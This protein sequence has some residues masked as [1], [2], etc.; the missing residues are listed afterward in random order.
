MKDKRI[1]TPMVGGLGDILTYY[2]DGELGHFPR[3]GATTAVKLWTACDQ[4]ADLFKH[5]PYVDHILPNLFW[6]AA[7]LTDGFRAWAAAGETRFRLMTDEERASVPWR[8]PEF[9]PSPGE[10]DVARKIEEAGPYIAIHPFAG[11]PARSLSRL[12]V[13]RIIV[14]AAAKNNRVVILGGDSYR[15]GSTAFAGTV[16]LIERFES[17]HPNVTS[18][19]GKYSVRLHAHLASKAAK[20]IGSVSAYNC[21]AHACNVPALVFGSADNRRAM[22]SGAGSIFARMRERSTPI[23]YT[24]TPIDYAKLV[25]AFC[26]DFR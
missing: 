3:L 19:V 16:Q 11:A 25:G 13:A 10:A 17:E 24:D 9:Y 5:H 22:L 23:H 15:S 6:P 12:G 2:L 7:G 21:V 20:F 26:D 4:A 1:F 14:G 18:L 8:R